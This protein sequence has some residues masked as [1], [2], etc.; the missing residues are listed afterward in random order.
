MQPPAQEIRFPEMAQGIQLDLT[1]TF[2]TLEAQDVGDFLPRHALDEAHLENLLLPFGQLG[3]LLQDPIQ[4]FGGFL[5]RLDQLPGG[6]RLEGQE[7]VLWVGELQELRGGGLL[8]SPFRV[9]HPELLK[10]LL[11]SQ[12]VELGVVGHVL[13]SPEPGEEESLRLAR[14]IYGKLLADLIGKRIGRSI[15]QD[16]LTV[17]YGV[18]GFEDGKLGVGL[19]KLLQEAPGGL[20]DVLEAEEQMEAPIGG[21]Q[22]EGILVG[23]V[24]EKVDTETGRE[25]DAGAVVVNE[26][27]VLM[28]DH[29]VFLRTLISFTR[30]IPHLV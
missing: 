4:Q 5:S 10:Q 30:I 29:D 24:G 2:G 16:A 9:D 23:A 26:S 18:H 15:A 3:N 17:R 13:G 12:L 7:Q 22:L 21:D 19:G 8:G 28:L 27:T 25:P 1:C 11:L 6:I 14:K 20:L